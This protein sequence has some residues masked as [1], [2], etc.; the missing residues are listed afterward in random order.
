MS[1]RQP[2][3]R[4]S[5]RGLQTRGQILQAARQLFMRSGYY[6]TS[7]YDL[8]EQAE[9]SKG[10]FF[11]HWKSKEDLALAVWQDVETQFEMQFFSIPR[12]DGRAR[13]E[14]ECVW[15]RMLE[16]K[17]ETTWPYVKIFALF[18]HEVKASDGEIGARV[19]QLRRRWR[20]MW[21]ELIARA[22]VQHDLRGDISSENLSFL[23]I[24]AISGVTLMAAE[25]SETESMK[26]AISTLRQTLLT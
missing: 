3:S 26:N 13:D 4:I 1:A 23:V 5:Q 9:I 14:M 7:V 25:E 12:S 15:T 16:L 24:C 20:S 11:H 21:H 22:Q 6:R 8:F 18:A 2:S 17:H 10:A 19:Q